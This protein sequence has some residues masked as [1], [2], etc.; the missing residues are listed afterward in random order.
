MNYRFD[1][2]DLYIHFIKVFSDQVAEITIL[3]WRHEM[4]IIYNAMKVGLNESC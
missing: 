1:H 2:Y 4:M 3:P